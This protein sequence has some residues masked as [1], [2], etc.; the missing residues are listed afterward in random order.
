MLQI[1]YGFSHELLLD[2]KRNYRKEEKKMNYE[3]VR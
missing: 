3:L 2:M 1:V